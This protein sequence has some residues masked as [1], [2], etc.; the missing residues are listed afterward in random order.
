MFQIKC[1]VSGGV[2]GTREAWLKNESSGLPKQFGTKEAADK[3][4]RKLTTTYNGPN[5]KATFQYSVIELE[6]DSPSCFGDIRWTR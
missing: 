5:A 6:D 1:R 4:A 3:E 2:T